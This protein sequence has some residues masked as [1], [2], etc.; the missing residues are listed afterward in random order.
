MMH[1]GA[2]NDIFV[3]DNARDNI[4][5][6]V[7]EGVDTVRSSIAFTLDAELEHLTLT[8]AA[9]ASGTGNAAANTIT[10]NSG[11]NL[12]NGLAGNDTLRG[13]GGND[14]LVGDAGKD[15]LT[16][17]TGNDTFRFL[18]KAHSVVGA[19]A[20]IITDF[21]D[22]GMGVDKIDLSALFGAAL[23]YRHNQAFTAA[24]QVRI[25]DIAGADVI[26]EVN[27]VGT[28]GADFSIRLTGTTLASMSAADF[29]L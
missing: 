9:G 3:I 29:V 27:L 8:G 20:D 23:I 16:G 28:S 25:N 22:P 6:E 7:G 24:G 26:V 11:A 1:G 15:T 18:N 21:G 10:G 19:T 2:G 5:E 17:G 4:F 12:L 14:I 13:E